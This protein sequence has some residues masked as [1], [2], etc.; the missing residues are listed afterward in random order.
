MDKGVDSGFLLSVEEDLGFGRLDI[1]S[2]SPLSFA[3]IGDAVFSAL[4]RSYVLSK[5]NRAANTLH[6]M[7]S[8]YVKATAQSL[9]AQYIF[10]SLSEDEADIYKRGKN[11][12]INSHTRNA[13]LYEYK[14]ATGLEA[15]FGY[16]YLSGRNS[17]ILELLHMCIECIE[18][19]DNK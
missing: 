16:L 17:R 8:R 13:S 1:R 10:D 12:H 2:F 5:G 3:F 6:A 9:M 14:C 4:I 18:N 19:K 15:L 7:S 11:A